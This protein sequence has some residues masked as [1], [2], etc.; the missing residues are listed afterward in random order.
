MS[1][2]MHQKGDDNNCQ[3]YLLRGSH[4]LKAIAQVGQHCC[5]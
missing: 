5:L 1:W 3:I 4:L 2:V